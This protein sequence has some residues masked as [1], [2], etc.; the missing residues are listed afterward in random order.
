MRGLILAAAVLLA[1]G[2]PVLAQDWQQVEAQD[3][4]LARVADG[5]LAVN[6]AMCRQTMP[7]TGAILHSADQYAPGAADARFTQG[8]LAVASVQPG[9][10]AEAAGLRPDDAV[11]A[12]NGTSIATLELAADEHLR[13]G[14]FAVLAATPPEQSVT[15][16][17]ARDGQPH[18]LSLAAPR[19]CR[20]L[21]EISGSGADAASDG[22]VIQ[23]RYDFAANLSD[24]ELAIVVAHELAHA[25]LEH[26]RRKQEAG[27]DNSREQAARG[28]NR[29]ANRR[30]EVEADRL[31][32]H[33]LANAGYDPLIAVQF[34]RTPQGR[35]AN[36]DRRG[37]VYPSVRQRARQIERE[38]DQ[39]LPLR[40]GPSWPQHLLD[41]R[42]QPITGD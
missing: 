32:V 11:L 39:Y 41:L 15:L 30:A 33:L 28:R 7:L 34:W 2:Q 18:S 23:L 36:G 1:L 22:R 26:R 9:S 5:L 35:A 24:Q 38:V 16:L 21:V 31:S 20:V 6:A 42:D 25:I 40:T 4:R 13:E 37:G 10:P 29:A 19:G 12:I 17:V 3:L 27:I 8:L 14:A